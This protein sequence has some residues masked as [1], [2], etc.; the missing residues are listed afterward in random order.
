MLRILRRFHSFHSKRDWFFVCAGEDGVAGVV[1]A[2]Q[3]V[4]SSDEV[5]KTEVDL[6]RK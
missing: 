6:K 1:D 3:R 4:V 2:V 5:V